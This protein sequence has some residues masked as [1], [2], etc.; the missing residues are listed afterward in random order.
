[1]TRRIRVVQVIARLNVGGPAALVLAVAGG[2]DPDRYESVVLHGEVD[3]GEA[4]WRDIRDGSSLGRPVAGLGRAVR[5]GDDARAMAVLVREL[6]RLRPDVVHT[7]TAK[8]GALGRTAARLATRNGR[9]P[10]IVHTFHGHV[11]HGYFRPTV[12]R[13]IVTVERQLA[14]GTDRIITVGSPVRDDLLAAGI[15]RPE[16]YAVVPPGVDPLPT[17]PAAEARRSLGVPDGR[18]VVA[19][20]GRLTRIKR[21]DRAVDAMRA[22]REAGIDAHLVV[23]GDGDLRHTTERR[24]AVLGDAVTFLG[25]TSDI[26]RVLSAADVIVLTSDNEGMPVT[27]VEAA[28]AGVPAVA[29]DV[30]GVA[31]VVA[32]GATGLVVAPTAAA[33]GEGLVGLIGDPERRGRMGAAATADAARRFTTASMVGAHT[34]IYEEVLS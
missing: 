21:P 1:M 17:V 33:V 30:G 8:A 7:H 27:L 34:A 29:T 23:A 18:P 19:F 31:E 13:G 28:H 4:D 12:R 32:D 2:L 25:W 6:R 14:R 10:R 11:L 5:A 16:Q 15:G 26:G 20:V 24:A 22:V 9:R 3:E